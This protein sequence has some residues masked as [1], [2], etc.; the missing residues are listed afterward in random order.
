MVDGDP[1]KS[2]PYGEPAGLKDR[3]QRLL[4]LVDQAT[5]TELKGIVP[6]IPSFGFIGKTPRGTVMQVGS[7]P[8][9]PVSGA[10]EFG[11]GHETSFVIEAYPSTSEA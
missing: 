7:H 4:T 5:L 11:G 9:L 1:R 8:P 6:R 2:N 3:D 10:H